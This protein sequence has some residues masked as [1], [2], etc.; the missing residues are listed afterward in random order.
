MNYQYTSFGDPILGLKRGLSRNTVIAPYASLSAA[1]Y[2]P[3]HAVKNL[4][5]LRNL[6]ALR[7]YGYYDSIDFTPSRVPTGEKYAIVRN[8]TPSWHV[9]SCC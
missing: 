2:M 8:Y 6:G 7:P 9:H 4:K 1:Q 3:S 5:R